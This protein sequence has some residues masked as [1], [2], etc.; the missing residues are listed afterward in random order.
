[1]SINERLV[2]EHIDIIE[3]RCDSHLFSFPSVF[4]AT[5]QSARIQYS[6]RRKIETWRTDEKVLQESNLDMVT[7]FV[8]AVLFETQV[9]Q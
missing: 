3:L 9:A 2:G 4:S 1:M 6:N 8:I 7:G 5:K